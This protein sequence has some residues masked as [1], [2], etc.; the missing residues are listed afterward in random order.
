[1]MKNLILFLGKSQYEI[2]NV[3][4]AF[5]SAEVIVE[6]NYKTQ[7]VQ[8]CHI[9]NPISYAYMEKRVVHCNCHIYTDSTF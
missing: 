9:E 6:G 5:E 2:G 8:H 4:E 1:M 7:I 3:K